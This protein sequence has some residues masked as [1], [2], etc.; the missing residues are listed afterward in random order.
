MVDNVPQCEFGVAD[1]RRHAL[2]LAIA[3]EHEHGRQGMAQLAV[4][5]GLVTKRGAEEND[6]IDL[7]LVCMQQCMHMVE[8]VVDIDQHGDEPC[9]LQLLRQRFQ[10]G[11]LLRIGKVID[12]D[13]DLPR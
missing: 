8:V 7:T 12:E 9:G 10:N 2:D 11:Q 4:R 6:G 5:Q 13:G 1:Y 3:R